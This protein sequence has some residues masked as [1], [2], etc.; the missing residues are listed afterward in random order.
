[1][2]VDEIFGTHRLQR[3]HA[4]PD[5]LGGRLLPRLPACGAQTSALLSLGDS[6][7]GT[8]FVDPAAEDRRSPDHANGWIAPG[9]G[10]PVRR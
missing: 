3:L 5:I 1:M 2:T 9:R 4:P 7:G 10:G 6:G 8:V